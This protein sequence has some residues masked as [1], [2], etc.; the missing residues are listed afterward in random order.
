M[1]A[2]DRPSVGEPPTLAWEEV[3]AYAPVSPREGLPDDFPAVPGEDPLRR[4]LREVCT[5]VFAP[6]TPVG[7][8]L[9]DV[10]LV[11]VPCPP[12]EPPPPEAPP[13]GAPSSAVP[14]IDWLP[15]PGPP[16]PLNSEPA[17]AVAGAPAVSTS[18]ISVSV[19]MVAR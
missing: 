9:V 4:V 14:R 17:D 7:T 13:D 8:A 3:C 1:S 6:P 18:I 5:G 2:P 10:V 19:E 15:W 16:Y 12:A 11:D